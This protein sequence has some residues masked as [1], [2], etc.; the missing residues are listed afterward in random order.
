MVDRYHITKNEDGSHSVKKENGE[1]ASRVFDTQK[2]AQE[3]VEERYEKTDGNAVGL[4]HA[5]RNTDNYAKGQ[6]RD[7]CGQ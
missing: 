6:I 2:E 5:D 3:W 7:T 1:R 4:I